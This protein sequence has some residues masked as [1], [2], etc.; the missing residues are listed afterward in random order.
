MTLPTDNDYIIRRG[1][2]AG[3]GLAARLSEKNSSLKILLIEAGA[4]AA[5]HPLISTPLA[6]SARTSLTSTG[7]TLPFQRN[8]LTA[9][10]PTSNPTSAPEKPLAA[11]LPLNMGP[12]RGWAKLVDDNGWSYE[13]LLP[14]FRKA[15]THFDGQADPAVH[16][17]QGPIYNSPVSAS[18]LD[19]K[20]GLRELLRATWKHLGVE[21]IPDANAGSPIGLAELTENW[22]KGKRQNASEAYRVFQKEGFTVLTETTVARVLID[23][24]EG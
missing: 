4:N 19:H 9:A 23:D 2:I 14:Y 18:H 21:Y 24:S 11:A 5:T 1:G 17:L 16:G 8:T 3:Y 10:N 6:F 13:G 12:G 22:H 7:P 20:Y 15:A